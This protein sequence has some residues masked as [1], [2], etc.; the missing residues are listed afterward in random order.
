M[1][2]YTSAGAVVVTADPADSRT[3][4]LTQVRRNGETQTVAPKGRVEPR[5]SPLQAAAREVTEETG[6]RALVYVGYLGNQ[7]YEFVDDDG[8]PACKLVDWFLFATHDATATARETEGFATARFL[9]FDQAVAAS[10]HPEFHPILRRARD[11]IAWRHTGDLPF[12]DALSDLI[13][14]FAAKA[15][16]LLA[17]IRPAGIAV[18]GSAARGDFVEGWS[19]VDLVGWNID[20]ASPTGHGVTALADAA[21]AHTGIHTSLRFTD[22]TGHDITNA[23]PLYDMKLQA[24]LGRAA[25]DL[26]VIAG[27]RPATTAAM[28]ASLATPINIDLLHRYA[29]ERL[30]RPATNDVDR[31]DRARRTLSVLCSAARIT[32]NTV[33]PTASFRLPHV[34]ATLRRRWPHSQAAQLLTAYD[35]FRR[36][37]AHDIAAAEALAHRAPDALTELRAYVEQLIKPAI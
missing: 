32:A 4:L 24:V 12:S 2:N 14:S 9:T 8:T 31:A 23:G 29:T 34:A 27:T 37:G 33:D 28:T 7:S 11:V 17:P 26:S 30:A 16:V 35:T 6:L 3:L 15:A 20:P 21:Q 22:G 5:E 18:C 36:S 25:I 13:W 1:R 19:D 10:S